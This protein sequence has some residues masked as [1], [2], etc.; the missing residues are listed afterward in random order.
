MPDEAPL[1]DLSALD[2][3]PSWAKESQAPSQHFVR[4][5]RPERPQRP[6]R[7]GGG[8]GERRGGKPFG[9]GPRDQRGPR[10]RREGR[11]GRGPRDQRPPRRDERPEPPA[12]PFPWLRIAF[13]AT[14]PAVETVVQQ[15]RHT[16]KT[17]SLFEIARILLRNPASY[18]IELSS[19]SK[20]PEGPFYLVPADGSVWLSRETAVRHLLQA[21][22]ENFYRAEIVDIE[23]PKGNFSVVAVCGLSG[24]LLGPPNLH[25][26]E[27]RLRDLHREKFGR[28]DFEQFKSRLKMERDPETIE[29]W[30]A[31]A[32]KATRYYPAG[33]EEGGTALENLAAVEAHFAANLA[34]DQLLPSAT[35][36]VPGDPRIAVVDPAL[37]PLLAFAREEEA[38][39]PLRLAQSLS[40]ALSGA[41][42]RF[43][44]SANRTTFVAASRPRHLDL[45]QTVVSDSIKRILDAIRSAK[46]IR[47]PQLLDQLAPLP[48]KSEK[49]PGAPVA[50]PEAASAE[51]PALPVVIAPKTPEEL[52]RE[53]VVQDLLWLT[54]EGYVVEYAD[55]RLESVPP[56]KKQPE[57]AE[58]TSSSDVQPVP[59]AG[60][61][62]EV[63]AANESPETVA[64]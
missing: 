49:T 63:A 53:A 38:R 40:R 47:R 19:L 17:F 3:R 6:D 25:D 27:R 31:S 8:Q 28:M 36:S 14:D 33:A 41:G 60:P 16:G 48:P 1:L 4:D 56:P 45:A 58:K 13:T 5:D 20:L 26:Y 12:N 2:F 18:R 9:R 61:E 37:S 50:A 51:I 15:I 64:E 32:S 62:A 55:G 46:S 23:P 39:F 54:H 22:M 43:H 34:G 57:K 30:R 52:A 42:L 21:K 10:E 29:K 7:R 24:S 35:A 11:E 44:K 59:P